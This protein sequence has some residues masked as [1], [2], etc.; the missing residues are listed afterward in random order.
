M[1]GGYSDREG[2]AP[3]GSRETAPLVVVPILVVVVVPIF[4]VVLVVVPILVLDGDSDGIERISRP[5]RAVTRP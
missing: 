5:R 1:R 4:V 2:V 3:P